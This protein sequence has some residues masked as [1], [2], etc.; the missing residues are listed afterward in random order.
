MA[1]RSRRCQ[2]E[3]AEG[4]MTSPPRRSRRGFL[5]CVGIVWFA[6]HD[7]FSRGETALAAVEQANR[8]LCHPAVIPISATVRGEIREYLLSD[9]FRSTAIG[10]RNQPTR[11]TDIQPTLNALWA[12]GSA[13]RRTRLRRSPLVCANHVDPAFFALVFKHRLE[14]VERPSMQIEVAVIAPVSWV[15]GVTVLADSREVADYDCA[16]AS[17]DTLGNDILRERVQE[18]R[19]AVGTLLIEASRFA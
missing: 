18:V 11:L 17:F 3:R 16:G 7:L 19:P 2:D 6:V 5:C 15:A 8:W 10:V 12:V 4:P 1:Y 9:I 14:A 13:T